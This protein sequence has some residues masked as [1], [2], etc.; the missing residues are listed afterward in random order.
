MA[1]CSE[2]EFFRDDYKAK[3]GAGQFLN[4]LEYFAAAVAKVVDD[5]HVVAGIHKLHGGV[6]ANVAC[7]AGD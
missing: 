4:A 7:A 2:N 3:V 1:L 5:Y 6:R